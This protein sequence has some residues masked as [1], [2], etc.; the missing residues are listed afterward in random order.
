[1][2]GL[3]TFDAFPKT[4]EEYQKKSSKGGLS[5]LLT[6]FFLI[7]IAW[8]EFG[9]YFGGYIDEQYT[10]DPEVKE[11]IQINM[12]IFVNI[13]CKWLHI[14]ARDMTLDRKLAGEELKLEDMPFFIPFDTRVNDITEI[15]T[16]ELDRILGEAIPAE[17]REKIDMRQF[18]DENNHDETKHFVPEFNGCHVFGSIPVNRVTG[19]LQ[20]TAK[21][22][23][24]PDREKAPID[25]VNFAHV[26]NELSF[27]DF[28]PYIDNPLDNSAKF[29]QENPISAY[30]YH[31]N[32]IPTI[33]QKL[34]AEVD[35]N[36]YSVSEYHYTEADNAIRKAGRVPGIFLKYNFE[37][38]S[39]VVT[40][41]RL[42]FIQFVI[43]LVAILSFIVYIASWLFILVDTALVA[44]MGPK[45]SLRYQPSTKPQGIL[46]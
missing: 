41:K 45:W 26:I 10:V 2:A 8:T 24:Y 15:V 44:A 16:P 36:Q 3:R 6:Y 33:Y 29:D 28:Y 34:G 21:G 20:I 17:F 14:N 31:M 27:G 19:E 7:F 4:E 9:N 23:G 32:V 12:D 38:L 40:D 18:Y 46:E 42:S 25:E 11:D 13:P 30:V 43:R 22:M 35:T 37:P 39:I 1:M 5:S